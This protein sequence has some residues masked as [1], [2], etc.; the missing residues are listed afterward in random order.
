MRKIESSD[1]LYRSV[2]I[3]CRLLSVC[4][5]LL[6]V[7]TSLCHLLSAIVNLSFSQNSISTPLSLLRWLVAH[8]SDFRDSFWTHTSQGSRIDRIRPKVSEDLKRF[9]AILIVHSNK[10]PNYHPQNEIISFSQG[11]AD[12]QKHC[13]SQ[14]SITSAIS[15]ILER[16]VRCLQFR[17]RN[18]S[19][20]ECM[21]QFCMF[22]FR[23]WNM[24]K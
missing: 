15:E 21:F 8:W 24:Q 2:P 13:F 3:Y 22:Q 1:L 16:P 17:N 10:V 20:F 4:T 5:H 18:I 19:N 7:I 14:M 11:M 6:S 23:N 9:L 12:P